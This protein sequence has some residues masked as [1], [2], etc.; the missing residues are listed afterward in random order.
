MNKVTLTDNLRQQL[1]SRKSQKT[2]NYFNQEIKPET[3]IICSPSDIG[4][5]RNGGRQ[6]AFLGQ[7]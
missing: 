6:G 2:V 3:L 5:I 7:M 1:K 4:V